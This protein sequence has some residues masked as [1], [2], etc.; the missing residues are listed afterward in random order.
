VEV[1]LNAGGSRRLCG[2][3]AFLNLGSGASMP[4]APGP[5]AVGAEDSC[6]LKD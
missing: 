1:T 2:D 6:R 4:D 5:A 3:R